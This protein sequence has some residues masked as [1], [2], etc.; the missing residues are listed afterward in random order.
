MN[1]CLYAPVL[2][3]NF[4]GQPDF[5]M[6]HAKSVGVEAIE[7]FTLELND[8]T[9]K[10]YKHFAAGYGIDISGIVC[11]SYLSDLDPEKRLAG[12]D[13]VKRCVDDA[14]ANNVKRIMVD[15]RIASVDGISQV[16]SMEDKLFVRDTICEGLNKIV[17]Y[18]KG[19][20][21]TITLE[22]YSKHTHPFSTKEEVLYQLENVPGLRYTLDA[23]N[24]YC[25]K[26]DVLKAYELLKGYID[27]MHLKDWIEYEFGYY[28][29]PNMTPLDGCIMG[30]G[31]VP[32]DELL[33]RMKAD[34]VFDIDCILEL[35]TTEITKNDVEKSTDFIKKYF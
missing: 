3:Q 29:C 13:K 1:I 26:D 30:E 17:E 15:P 9:L 22:N 27:N 24:F 25:V 10:E 12:I 34:N 20:G 16:R 6:K 11:D 7:I 35:N 4:Y 5:T 14:S 33:K 23:G 31:V 2:M 19:S 21:V 8:K 32:L 28:L 18:A